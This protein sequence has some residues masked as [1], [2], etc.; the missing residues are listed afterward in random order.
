MNR[1][2]I[3]GIAALAATLARGETI[4]PKALINQYCVAC[5][6][7]KLKTG[8]LELD[9]LDVQNVGPQAEAWEKSCARFAPE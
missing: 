5:H 2:G 1:I 8:G 3:F 7:Q 9:K 6:N 4:E